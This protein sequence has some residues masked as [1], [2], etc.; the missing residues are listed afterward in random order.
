[1]Y[2]SNYDNINE[3]FKESCELAKPI[4]YFLRDTNEERKNNYSFNDMKSDIKNNEYF[5]D[6]FHIE[7]RTPN[8]DD[9]RF[10]ICANKVDGRY[11]WGFYK[12]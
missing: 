7:Q 3:Y 1:V 5:K 6:Y 4:M 8:Y 10:H 2:A 9:L 11:V 12:K